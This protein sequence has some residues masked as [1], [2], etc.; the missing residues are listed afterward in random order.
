LREA[1]GSGEVAIGFR[2]ESERVEL[3]EFLCC[4]CI[5]WWSEVGEVLN[6]IQFAE[7]SAKSCSWELLDW[8]GVRLV[9]GIVVEDEA[10]VEV[11]LLAESRH[12]CGWAVVS[13]VIVPED[14]DWDPDEVGWVCRGA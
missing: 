1:C 6:D 9:D 13:R 12:R 10:T 8:C 11:E 2:L 14:L 4:F 3:S 5:I 7:V